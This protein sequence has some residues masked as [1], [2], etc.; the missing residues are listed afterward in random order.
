ME[1]N[2]LTC[3]F[4]GEGSNIIATIKQLGEPLLKFNCQTKHMDTAIQVMEEVLDNL[5]VGDAVQLAGY[6]LEEPSA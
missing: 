4:E 2:L 5:C 1:F 3:E 6:N